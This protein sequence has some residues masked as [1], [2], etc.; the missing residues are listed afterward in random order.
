MAFAKCERAS[1]GRL[2]QRPPRQGREAGRA[3]W[4]RDEN[5]YNYE[6]YDSIKDNPD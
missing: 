4:R 5:I 3:A 1:F 6:N 2:R